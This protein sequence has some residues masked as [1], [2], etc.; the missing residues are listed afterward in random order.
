MFSFKIVPVALLSISLASCAPY[1]PQPLPTVPP[2]F[3]PISSSVTISDHKIDLEV[4]STE[5]QLSKG[6]MSREALPDNRGML[7][8]FNP[9]RPVTFWMKNT[10]APLDIIFLNQGKVLFIANDVQ[11]CKSDP[12]PV[13]PSQ[14]IFVDKVLEIRAGLANKLGLQTGNSLSL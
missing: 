9:P 13:Y 10:I 5:E 11:P 6:L 4:A 14:P 12:C 8:V 3:L 1:L 7:F 2:Q